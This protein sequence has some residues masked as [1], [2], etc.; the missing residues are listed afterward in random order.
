MIWAIRPTRT[1]RAWRDGKV[2]SGNPAGISSS[3]DHVSDA[4]F[5]LRRC[6]LSPRR[7]SGGPLSLSRERATTCATRLPPLAPKPVRCCFQG[8]TGLGTRVSCWALVLSHRREPMLKLVLTS[9][10][11]TVANPYSITTVL[12]SNTNTRSS[13]CALTA[14]A[15]TLRS[16]SRP[17]CV[18]SRTSSRCV[19]LATS[20][21]MIGPASSSAVT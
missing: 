3:E 5:R 9:R 21:S 14:R 8:K 12:F 20:C 16:I 13:R 19:T 15:S 1:A 7:V 17:V 6:S 18:R 2:C 11:L 4:Q 10:G